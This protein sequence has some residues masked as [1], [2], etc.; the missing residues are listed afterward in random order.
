MT[1][2]SVL[3]LKEAEANGWAGVRGGVTAAEWWSLGEF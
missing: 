3:E 2:I 1:I